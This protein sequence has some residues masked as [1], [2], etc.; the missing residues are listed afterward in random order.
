ME[1]SRP[2]AM[3]TF[4]S[5]APCHSDTLALDK[6]LSTCRALHKANIRRLL[7]ALELDP[8]KVDS[9][10]GGQALLIWLADTL[11]GSRLL[12]N[13]WV[14]VILDE[15]RLNIQI[16]GDEILAGIP[17]QRL[18]AAYLAVGDRQFVVI[19]RRIDLFD[20]ANA[21]WVAA[22]TKPILERINYDLATLFCRHYY[23]P[24]V[25]GPDQEQ[26]AS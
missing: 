7:R 24:R 14:W 17:S 4:C 23:A 9:L 20:L 2:S 19:S 5:E 16:F 15:L 26:L 1:E 11:I 6:V 21:E 3:N 25:Q 12:P 10:T 18:P 8:D 13:D 22:P